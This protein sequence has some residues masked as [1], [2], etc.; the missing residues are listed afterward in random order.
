M[1]TVRFWRSLEG[2]IA[3]DSKFYSGTRSYAVMGMQAA[4]RERTARKEG[5]IT[6][7][8]SGKDIDTTPFPPRFSDLKHQLWNDSLADSWRGVLEEL[9]VKTEEVA[10]RG[11]EASYLPSEVSTTLT[12]FDQIVPKVDYTEIEAG[13]APAKIAE[14]KE[15][16]VVIVRGAVPEKVRCCSLDF[17]H[18]NL[19]TVSFRKL[20]DGKK[21]SGRM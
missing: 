6:S 18:F 20:L 4:P 16:G 8:F 1:I 14:I 11:S 3:L 2:R 19:F 15:A 21:L 13:L 7:V 10:R 17:L 12:N 5:D 9:K